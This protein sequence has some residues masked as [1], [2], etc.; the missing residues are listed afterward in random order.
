[1]C[2]VQ[3]SYGKKSATYHK[4]CY[5]SK[6]FKVNVSHSEEYQCQHGISLNLYIFNHR[7]LFI[8]KLYHT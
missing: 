4:E 7:L 8:K 1:M 3:S 6:A 5:Y 2:H